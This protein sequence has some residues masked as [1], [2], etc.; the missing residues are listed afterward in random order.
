M[1]FDRALELAVI[2]SWEELVAPNESSSKHVQCED[3][4][5]LA[6][7]SVEVWTV[8][9]RGSEKPVCEY[10][11]SRSNPSATRV[12]FANFYYSKI[13]ADNLD[14]IIRDQNEFSRTGDRSIHGLLQID[15]LS[16]E[17]RKSATAWSQSVRPA[18]ADISVNSRESYPS[19]P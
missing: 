9:N 10:S 15:P 4:P 17:D 5:D 14:F 3:V 16:E 1:E 12:D 2:S 13:L 11:I 18:P 6:M 7:N 8:T 19:R